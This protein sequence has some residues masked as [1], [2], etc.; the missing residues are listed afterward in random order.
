MDCGFV[1]LRGQDKD[2]ARYKANP[3]TDRL[4]P[5]VGWAISPCA[6]AVL[7]FS[8]ADPEFPFQAM[9]QANR[10]DVALLPVPLPL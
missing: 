8:I 4:E 10:V 5:I 7:L 1:E 9:P 2:G 3:M 6:P